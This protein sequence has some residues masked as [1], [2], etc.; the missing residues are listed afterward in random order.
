MGHVQHFDQAESFNPP[1]AS[2][3]GYSHDQ[4]VVR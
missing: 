1:A 3:P 2:I 4:E